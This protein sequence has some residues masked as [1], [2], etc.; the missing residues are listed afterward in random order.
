MCTK[1]KGGFDG[2]GKY[3]VLLPKFE[4]KSV[5]GRLL[6]VEK[7]STTPMMRQRCQLAEQAYK[8]LGARVVEKDGYLIATDNEMAQLLLGQ[9]AK[10]SGVHTIFL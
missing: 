5:D 7:L 3:R 2:K 4:K 6:E 10:Q 1:I 9:K 8:S